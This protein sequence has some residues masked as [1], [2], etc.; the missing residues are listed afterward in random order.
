[1]PANALR[2][3]VRQLEYQGTYV[4]VT[5]QTADPAAPDCVAYVEEEVF[6]DAPV[7]IG[8]RVRC[9]W[10]ADEARRLAATA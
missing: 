8:Q 3:R 9:T 2:G 1:V 7:A 4:K 5:L 10:P 6:F